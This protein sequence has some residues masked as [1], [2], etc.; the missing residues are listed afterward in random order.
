MKDYYKIL[1]T[2]PDV[3]QNVIKE[4]YR[5]LVQAWHPDKFQNPV[6]KLRAEEKLK[7]LNEAYEILGN[8]VKRAEYDKRRSTYSSHEQEYRKRAEQRQSGNEYHRQETAHNS[9]EAQSQKERAKQEQEKTE[10]RD[11]NEKVECP[12]CG[13]SVLRYE[14]FRCKNCQRPYICFNHQNKSSFLCLECEYKHT[15]K[16]KNIASKWL[17]LISIILSCATS[18]LLWAVGYESQSLLQNS[19]GIIFITLFINLLLGIIS[20]ILKTHRMGWLGLSLSLI[21]SLFA[22]W[23]LFQDY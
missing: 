11:T 5:F 14:T 13:K 19:Q 6:Q 9:E 18:I 23:L 15:T 8:P 22:Y 7:E 21:N 20:L 4:Q 10:K 12:I 3:S 16:R 1:E 2:T 17:R